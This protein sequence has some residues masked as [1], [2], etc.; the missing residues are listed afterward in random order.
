MQK[1]QVWSNTFAHV[2]GWVCPGNGLQINLVPRGVIQRCVYLPD[3]LGRVLVVTGG[4]LQTSNGIQCLNTKKSD[5]GELYIIGEFAPFVY[6]MI[7]GRTKT[8]PT[9]V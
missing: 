2:P 7:E 4:R 1:K 9:M 6:V 3:L 8:R 5:C